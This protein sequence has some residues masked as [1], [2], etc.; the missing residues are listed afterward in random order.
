MFTLW[1]VPPIL[2]DLSV[3]F[4]QIDGFKTRPQGPTGSSPRQHLGRETEITHGTQSG[5]ASVLSLS[6]VR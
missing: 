3:S 2:Q 5:M 1:R 6:D 4:S